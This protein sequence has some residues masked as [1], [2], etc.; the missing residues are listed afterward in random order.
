MTRVYYFTRTGDSEKIAASIAAQTGGSCFPIR[1]NKSWKGPVGFMRGGYYASGKKSLPAAY[2]KPQEGDTVYLCFP[3]WAG[4]FPPAVRT[5]I[6]E[7]G[8]D[9]IIAVPTSKASHLSDPAGFVRVIEVI[10][11]DKTVKV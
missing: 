7:V 11:P 9:Q 5:F 8:R 2:E 10:G 4:S 1:D 6:G 3:I